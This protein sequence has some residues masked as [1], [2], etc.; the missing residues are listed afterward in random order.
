MVAK[1]EELDFGVIVNDD[2]VSD[3]ETLEKFRKFEEANAKKEKEIERKQLQEDPDRAKE[4]FRGSHFICARTNTILPRLVDG[5][6]PNVEVDNHK[7]SC[8]FCQEHIQKREAELQAKA[9]GY[10][11]MSYVLEMIE[12]A[13]EGL[14]QKYRQIDREKMEKRQNWELVVEHLRKDIPDLQRQIER[15]TREMHK[16]L[17]D[18]KENELTRQAAR[19]LYD[20]YLQLS[21]RDKRLRKWRTM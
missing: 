1:Q 11:R 18:E 20:R 12:R 5:I 8:P 10:Q 4:A 9:D 2:S 21:D 14:D 16:L 19:E 17:N 3:Y 6:N 15:E 13:K 7:A